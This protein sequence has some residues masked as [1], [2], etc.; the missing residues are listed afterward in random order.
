MLSNS[1]IWHASCDGTTGV[2]VETVVLSGVGSVGEEV[3]VLG[4]GGEGVGPVLG[5]KRK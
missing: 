4:V 2:V 5:P 3:L 1:L